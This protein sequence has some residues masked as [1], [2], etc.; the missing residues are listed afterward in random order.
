MSGGSPTRVL[1]ADDDVNIREALRDLLDSEPGIEVVA[2]AADAVEAVEAATR[3]R[4][5]VAV[6]DVKMPGGGGPAAARGIRAA[7]PDTRIVALSAYG[8][9]ASVVEMLRAGAVAYLVK[10]ALA[11]E[12]T[13]TIE[14][15]RRGESVVSPDVAGSVVRELAERLAADEDADSARDKLLGRI[16]SVIDGGG[17]RSVY[18]PIIHLLSGL[19]TGVEA[20]SRFE[21]GV[22]LQWF[23]E[24]G[25]V[26]LREE[27]EV[28]AIEAALA[29]LPALPV[30]AYLSL[31]LSPSTLLRTDVLGLFSDVPLERIVIE[32]TE[33]APVGDYD[34]LTRALR[35]L[36]DGG[37]RLAV[38]DTGA[39]L[40]SLSHMLLLV[41]D[42]IKLDASIIRG[43]ESDVPRRAI[44]RAMVAFAQEVQT[45]IV[46]EGIETSAEL[47]TLRDLGVTHGQGFLLARPTVPPF[48]EEGILAV[49][50][51]AGAA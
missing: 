47:Q 17:V 28:R 24:A 40:A 6:L 43:I 42:I 1:I 16:R 5:D 23:Q 48:D 45:T 3:E 50:G 44:S 4:P 11:D 31:N 13:D 29:G 33:R 15:V 39:G 32:M 22:P 51:V 35:P 9:R 25:D 10:G 41:P 20:L 14:R 36:R 34:R 30:H 18:Q 8:D 37:I 46:A 7:S 27:L 19:V 49:L 21:T 26:G 2:V 38:D 12:V